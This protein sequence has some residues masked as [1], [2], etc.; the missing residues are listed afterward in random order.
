MVTEAVWLLGSRPDLIQGVFRAFAD[1]V[2]R[3]ALLTENDLAGI[4]RILE[5]YASLRPELADAVLV[6]LAERAGMPTIFTLDRRDFTV[7]RLSRNRPLN[8]IP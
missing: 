8:L 5:T 3:L 2:L 4:A 7:Y 1:G 6:H